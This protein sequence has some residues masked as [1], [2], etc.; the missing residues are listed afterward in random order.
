MEVDFIGET[1]NTSGCKPAQSKVSA[2][3]EMPPPTC[4]KQVNH[5]LEWSIICQNSQ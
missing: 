4:K 3:T 1:Y 5:S 2:I